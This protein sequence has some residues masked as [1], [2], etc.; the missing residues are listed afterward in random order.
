M[1]KVNI[2]IPVYNEQGNIGRALERIKSEIT[3]PYKVT[4]VYDFD[5]DNSL[6]E[7]RTF[8]EK[9]KI[10]LV[11]LKNYLG[12]GA[13]NAIKSGLLKSDAEYTIVTMA[14][15][16]DPPHVINNMFEIAKNKNCDIVCGSRYM[17][18]GSQNSKTF[19]KSFLSKF[20]GYTLKY[21]AGVPTH[22]ATNSFKLYSKRVIENIKIE[23]TGGFELGLELVIKS[24]I[25]GYKIDEVPTTWED[26]SEG[27]S[28]FQLVNWLPSYLRWYF[29]A[30]KFRYLKLD[31]KAITLNQVH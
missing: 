5:E 14:D 3:C 23:S 30:Y 22:D 8:N 24:Y 29:L 21:F 11:F 28:R 26:R 20:A 25:L 18:G 9:L 27:E 2:V 13:L 10:D 17:S 19:L 16:S 6:P 12:R 7:A 15:L 4:I 1:N 31:K